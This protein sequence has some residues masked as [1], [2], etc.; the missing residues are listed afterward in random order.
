MSVF[1]KMSYIELVFMLFSPLLCSRI[2]DKPG[3]LFLLC[4]YYY[5]SRNYLHI[6]LNIFLRNH[7]EYSL[8][9]FNCHIYFV[10]TWINSSSFKLRSVIRDLLTLNYIALCYNLVKTTRFDVFTVF[11]NLT[12]RL[13]KTS[14]SYR[15]VI[16]TPIYQLILILI[17]CYSSLT[18]FLY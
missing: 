8:K 18:G 7:I 6:I 16:P 1:C 9:F 5:I 4:K 3:N 13:I 11:S 17:L 2:S 14:P 15:L 12:K 10:L